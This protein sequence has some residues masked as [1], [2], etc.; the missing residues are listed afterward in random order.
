MPERT[1]GLTI[2]L[3]KP[4]TSRAECLRAAKVTSTSEFEFPDGSE[5]SLHTFSTPPQPPKWYK[6]LSAAIEN[7]PAVL[8]SSASAVLFVSTSNRLFAL[9]FGYGRSLLT[10]GA[11]EEDFGLKVTLNSVNRTRSR[12]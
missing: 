4:N 11:W 5:A 1:I 8:S 7:P 10:P 9:T 6:F 12:Q 2:F 3:I